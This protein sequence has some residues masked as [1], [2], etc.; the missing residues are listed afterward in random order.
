MIEVDCTECYVSNILH[1]MA[2]TVGNFHWTPEDVAKSLT[3]MLM[4]G[5][6][7][8]GYTQVCIYEFVGFLFHLEVDS[9]LAG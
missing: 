7:L 3:C 8:T 5:P 9:S 4:S 6:L 1:S 2:R